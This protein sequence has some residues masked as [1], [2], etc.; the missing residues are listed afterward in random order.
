LVVLGCNEGSGFSGFSLALTVPTQAE[1]ERAFAA[2]GDG[3]QVQ[4]P[5]TKT[6]WSPC[7]GMPTDRF[8]I[9]WISVSQHH[10]PDEGIH[11]TKRMIFVFM[12]RQRGRDPASIIPAASPPRT[13]SI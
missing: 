3:G 7:F 4:M 1:A 9:G 2:L 8:G 10:R 13:S 11:D 6:F 5:L 12:Q